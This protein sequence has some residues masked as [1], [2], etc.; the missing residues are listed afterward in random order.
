MLEALTTVDSGHAQGFGSAVECA[1][2]DCG[3]VPAHGGYKTQL[4]LYFT[5]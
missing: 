2:T 3:T 5:F 1:A 4:H